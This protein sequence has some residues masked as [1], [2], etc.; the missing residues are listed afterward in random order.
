LGT[1]LPNL[2]FAA[3]LRKSCESVDESLRPIRLHGVGG[4]S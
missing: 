2:C 3:N 1:L 4:G